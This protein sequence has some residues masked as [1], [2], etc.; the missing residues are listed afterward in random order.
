MR[1]GTEIRGWQ[2]G[3]GLIFE[4]SFEHEFGIVAPSGVQS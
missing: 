3:K 4:D 2:E 1:V